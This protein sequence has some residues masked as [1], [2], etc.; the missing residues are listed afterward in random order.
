MHK[1]FSKQTEAAANNDTT[2]ARV[3]RWMYRGQ[4]PNWM[5]R[6]ANRAWGIGAARGL[7]RNDVVTLEVTG[8]TSGRVISFPLVMAVVDGERYLVSMLGDN[9]QWVK[10]CEQP[11]VARCCA[12]AAVRWSNWKSCLPTS[13]HL[14]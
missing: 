12:A 1:S 11:V 5:A 10:T 2:F 9:T 4:R 6:I 3:K 8:R 13:A 7:T 14:S